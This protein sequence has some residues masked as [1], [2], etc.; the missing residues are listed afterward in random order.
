MCLAHQHS[1][2]RRHRN[3][4]SIACCFRDRNGQGAVEPNF[5]VFPEHQINGV[6]GRSSGVRRNI[7]DRNT[8]GRNIRCS[9]GGANKARSSR[10]RSRAR[11]NNR[12]QARNSQ[13]RKRK[14]PESATQS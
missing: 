12:D 5:R 9:I 6:D 1:E 14:E 8:R 10:I 7:R 3:K 13:V 11:R 2:T 4:I